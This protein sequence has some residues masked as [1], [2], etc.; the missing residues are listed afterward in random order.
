MQEISRPPA[1]HELSQTRS[2]RASMPAATVR[3]LLVALVFAFLISAWNKQA[4]LVTLTSQISESTPPIA[5]VMVLFLVLGVGG[6]LRR[7]A[8]RH[9]AGQKPTRLSRWARRLIFTPGETLVVF[10]FLAIV[11]AMPGVGLFRQIMPSLMVTQYFGMPDNHLDEMAR[12]I[13]GSWAPTDPEVARLF[14]EGSDVSLPSFGLDRI[15]VIGDALE[16]AVRYFAAPTIVDWKHWLV[17]YLLWTG[18]LSAYFVTAFCLITL[19]R[20][21]WEEDERLSFPVSSL[22]VEMIRPEGS[23]LSGQS[24][25]RDPVVWIGFSLAVLYNA[26]NALKVFNPALPALG[27]SYPLGNIFTES[28]WDTMRGF[29]VFYKPELLG[30][31]YLVPMDV[32]FSIWVSTIAMWVV[33]PFAKI[34]GYTPSGFPF[35]TNQGMGAYVLLGAYALWS[36][37]QRLLQI[38]RNT[39]GNNGDTDD[40][41][42]PLSNRFALLATIVGLL[43]VIGMPI[44]YGVVPW[45]ALT[46]FG[47]MFLVLIVYC[48]N[49]AEMGFP[50]VWGYPLYKQRETMVNFLGSAPFLPGGDP[51]SATLLSMFGWL[52]RSVNQAITST[53]IEGQFAAYKLGE[54]RRVL[55][56]VVIGALVFGLALAFLVNLSAFYEYGG[57]VLSSA[58]GNEGGQMTQE[59]LGQFKAISQWMDRPEA[60]NQIKIGYTIVGSVLSLLMILGRRAWV[61]FP[62]HPGGY[63]LAMCHE[64]PYMWFPALLI[65]VIKWSTLHLGGVKAYRRVAPGFLAFTLGHFFSV[66][67]WSLIGLYAG[68]FVR[69]YTVWFL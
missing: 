43:I 66:G 51:K 41:E 26:T 31:G 30:L 7:L 3:A 11:C 20:R 68:E 48:H 12:N 59:V 49:R 34:A 17:P 2:E 35:M 32:L 67:L 50:V 69:Q 21:H 61:R 18:Y 52:Q 60:P 16:G 55:A 58:G 62:L 23:L 15:P 45:M 28:P 57:L 42:E 5:A 8:D 37:R 27:I 10:Y 13:P 39:F 53:G 44:A 33:R 4:E 1:G 22:A 9:E 38:A 47:I 46:Y 19:F 24:F 36:G 29:S 25:F 63:A 40:R 56:K 6:L 64:G 65:W 14:W 54:D